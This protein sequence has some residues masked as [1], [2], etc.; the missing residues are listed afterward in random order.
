VVR[1]LKVVD[2]VKVKGHWE[3]VVQE[4]EAVPDK[5]VFIWL[6]FVSVHVGPLPSVLLIRSPIILHLLCL[7]G[8]L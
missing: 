2:V 6:G 8:Y 5:S 7:P 3:F 4:E 1:G